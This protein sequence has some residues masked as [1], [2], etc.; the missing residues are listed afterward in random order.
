MTKLEQAIQLAMTMHAGQVDK[1]GQP[2]I[3]HLLRV[4][5]AVQPWGEEHMIAAV[6]H[7]GPEDTGIS[8]DL[9][10]KRFGMPVA[11]AVGHLTKRPGEPYEE[12]YLA[13]VMSNPIALV[14]KT[15][16]VWDN[17]QRVVDLP[18][19]ERSRLRDKYS[20]AFALLEPKV[21]LSAP[22]VFGGVPHGT[23]DA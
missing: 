5:L 22:A 7:D 23:K 19:P 10:L 1:A 17:L 9:I 11:V 2:Y 14:V 12:E 16:D 20:R 21:G 13:R 6:L 18:E 15:M 3:L 8:L 4:M